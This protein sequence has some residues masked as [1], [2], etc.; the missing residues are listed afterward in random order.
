M[1]EARQILQVVATH[2]VM[3]CLVPDSRHLFSLKEDI[4]NSLSKKHFKNHLSFFNNI[5]VLY[6]FID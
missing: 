4:Y 3:E 2:I 5:L 6:L 1:M